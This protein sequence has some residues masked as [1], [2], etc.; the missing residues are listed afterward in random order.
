MKSRI[1]LVSVGLCLL[2]GGLAGCAGQPE[3]EMAEAEAALQDA[4]DV[5]QAE[6][7]APQEYQDAMAAMDAAKQEIETQNERFAVMRNYDT[8]QEN[9]AK[10]TTAAREAKKAA[11]T[12]KDLA[13]DEAD[14]K[15]R[16]A[17]AAI[18]IAREAL[19]K[20]PVT[21][22]TRPDIQLFN[23]DLDGLGQSLDQVQELMLSE[24]YTGASLKA[25][26]IAQNANNIAREL[27]EARERLG[28]R[29]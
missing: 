6:E 25:E 17:T 7:Y 21:K 9:L 12:N 23:S 20:A 2:I 5:A 27:T 22:D 16:E 24:D 15:V 28:G 13:R 3:T 19:D 1:R 10:A 26:T 29:R 11:Q 18:E 4:R 14:N 8:A